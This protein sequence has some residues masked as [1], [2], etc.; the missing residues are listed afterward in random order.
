MGEQFPYL[1]IQLPVGFDHDLTYYQS[2]PMSGYEDY[3]YPH[4]EKSFQLLSKNGVKVKSPHHNEWPENHERMTPEEL[5]GI[6]MEKCY[7]QMEEC[8]GIIMLEGWPASK[9]ARMELQVA[10]NRSWPVYYFCLRDMM[11]I[12]MNKRVN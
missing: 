10:F 12:D 8:Q 4:F 6:M 11:L 7:I 5:W 2:G 9:G 3:N 1:A